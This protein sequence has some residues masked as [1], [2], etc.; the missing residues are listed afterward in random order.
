MEGSRRVVVRHGGTLLEPDGQAVLDFAPASGALAP[1]TPRGAPEPE[2][3]RALEWFERGC[4]LDSDPAHYAEAAEAY[5]RAVALDPEFADAHCNLGAVRFNQDRR[6]AARVCFER[7]LEIDCEHPEAHLNLAAL[8]EE[9]GAHRAALRHYQVALAAHP[10]YAD[11]HVSL[12]LLYER[13][14]EPRRARSHWRRYLRLEPCGTWAELARR[15][16]RG[17]PPR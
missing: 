10:G 1:L 14:G 11:A 7:A 13:L 17:L 5:A 15:G 2:R 12:A 4:A 3:E 16:L 8:L 6:A 9:D